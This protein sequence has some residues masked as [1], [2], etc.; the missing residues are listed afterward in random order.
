MDDE[1]VFVIDELT[2]SDIEIIDDYNKTI[3]YLNGEG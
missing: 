3:E 1:V 2:N